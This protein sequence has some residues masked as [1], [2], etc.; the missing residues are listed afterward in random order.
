MKHFYPSYYD[1]F[2]CIAADCPQS[3][4]QGWDVVIDENTENKYRSIGGELGERLR[5]ALYTD[6]D[7]DRIFR[8][9]EDKK[10]PFWD[11]DRLCEIY[12]A[13]GEKSLCETC[14]RF[15]RI[16]MEYADFTEHTLA[17]ACPEA[18]RL[19]TLEDNAYDGFMMD[20]PEGCGDYGAELMS[21]L[22]G[23]RRRA[24]EILSSDKPLEERLNELTAFAEKIQEELCPE[25]KREEIKLYEIY[26]ELEYIDPSNREKILRAIR[27]PV[28]PGK[29]ESSLSRLAL[30]FLYR[31]W[32][33]AVD[34]LRVSSTAEF[35]R[36][37]V[38]IIA[39]LSA[40]EGMSTAEA[41]QLYS[42]EIEQSYE[43]TKSLL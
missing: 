13:L 25:E 24:A 31:Y 34:T 9:A 40:H 23:T 6:Q 30:Y 35:I 19:I 27:E 20:D 39:A 7:G 8:L 14:A 12:K 5:C 3:C 22:L 42:K 43:N 37:S 18:A 41:A 38:R 10:C 4:C 36:S 15:P 21:F 33:N 28:E 26:G 1:K 29:D 11:A 16:A 32:L 2:R 17:L